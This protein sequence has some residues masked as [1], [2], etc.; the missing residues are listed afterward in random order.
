[1]NGVNKT[2]YIPLY[3][4]ALVSNRDIILKDETA[5]YIWSQESFKLKGKSKSKW[6]AFYMAMRA[7][8]FDDWLLLKMKDNPNA[9][10][11]HLGCGMDSRINRIKKP[12]YIWYDVDFPDVIRTRKN[13]Y[14]E[15]EF[16]KMLSADL[17]TSEWLSALPNG[18]SAIVLLEGVS[19]YLSP[20]QLRNLFTALGKRFSFVNLFIDCYT[21]FAAK[22][23]KYKNPVNDVGVTT[24]YGMDNPLQMQ[25]GTGFRFISQHDITPPHLINELQG[26]EKFI[27]KKVFA[28]K[29]SKKL[30]RLYEYEKSTQK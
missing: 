12:A 9:V 30:Y 7:K 17:T 18:E 5:E 11:L 13:Y 4:K 27:F 26:T 23:S 2:L 10:V 25:D 1:M 28:G 22:I 14:T 24:L 16:Y 6:L 20:L 19:M 3:G 15:N 29:F 8:V 21:E